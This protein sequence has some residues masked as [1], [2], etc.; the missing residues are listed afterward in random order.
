MK[1][2]M[3]NGWDGGTWI[4]GDPVPKISIKHSKIHST[5]ADSTDTK[6]QRG[7]CIFIAGDAKLDIV[8]TEFEKCYAIKEGGAIYTTASEKTSIQ[9]S[10]FTSCESGNGGVIFATPWEKKP[11]YPN[12]GDLTILDST[13]T[14]NKAT[15]G[16]AGNGGSV[17]YM[18][19]KPAD[20]QKPYA[21]RIST[22][23]QTPEGLLKSQGAGKMIKIRG[24]SFVANGAVSGWGGVF[25]LGG[26]TAVDIDTS[27]FK[28][29]TAK[30]AGGVFQLEDAV[31]LI[32]RSS[33]F[34]DNDGGLTGGVINAV[35]LTGGALH[36]HQREPGIPIIDAQKN[37]NFFGTNTDGSASNDMAVSWVMA[38]SI[39]KGNKAKKGNVL[40]VGNA[41]SSQ[42]YRSKGSFVNMLEVQREAEYFKYAK[43][44]AVN[45]FSDDTA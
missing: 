44:A 25:Y 15:G 33:T 5:A 41:D 43:D 31:T 22:T 7:G 27:T 20:S 26:S 9:N 14:S 12:L 28:K 35:D 40:Y 11:E 3:K 32:V 10:T 8:E 36:P 42:V 38:N 6:V 16:L 2:A 13:F 4:V 24:S 29:N 17:I 19:P 34:E 45:K 18:D 1:D 39:L 37:S 30:Q 23:G 21:Q